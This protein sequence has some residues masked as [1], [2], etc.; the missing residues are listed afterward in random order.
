MSDRD[1][2]SSSTRR[3]ERCVNACRRLS[4]LLD[5]VVCV[6]ITVTLIALVAMVGYSVCA[7]YLF[8]SPPTWTE[9]V[10][11]FLIIGVVFISLRVTFKRGQQIGVTFFIDKLPRYKL[12]FAVLS[13]LATLFFMSFACV[14]SYAFAKFFAVYKA[15]ATGISFYWL[16]LAVSVGCGLAAFESALLLIEESCTHKLLGREAEQEKA[17]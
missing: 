4:D 13:H 12:L 14:Q 1:F 6:P 7:R 2:S 3:L 16:Y 10:S 8:A 15:P 11:L 9:E 17:A 5:A